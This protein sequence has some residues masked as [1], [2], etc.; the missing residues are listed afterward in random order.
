[1]KLKALTP[2]W[3]SSDVSAPSDPL[4]SLRREMDRI[5]DSFS[6]DWLA[7]MPELSNG[8]LMPKVNVA[9]T[10]AGLEVTAELPGV[11]QKDIEV[12]V[13]DGELTLRAKHE[14]SKEEKDDKK[15]YH[16][17]ERSYGTFMRRLV[18]PFEADADKVEAHFEKGVLK[19][20]VPRSK[21][22][23]KDVRKIEVKAG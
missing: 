6:R 2:F 19:V 20:V 22:A 15:H 10:D 5:F 13:S 3:R 4:V 17:V 11:D 14:A 12:Q 18:L 9:E 1:M 23:A 8:F 7:P 16:L 21:A